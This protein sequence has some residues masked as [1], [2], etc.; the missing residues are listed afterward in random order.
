MFSF[1][2]NLFYSRKDPTFNYYFP[3]CRFW[4]MAMGGL[5]SVINLNLNSKLLTNFLGFFGLFSILFS[6]FY[7]NEADYYPGYIGLIPTIGTVA[8]IIAGKNSIINYYVLSTRVFT[9]IGKISFPMYLW[10]WPLLVF[11]RII[12][13][14]LQ[15]Y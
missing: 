15:D 6:A 12:Y 1:F 4:E 10:H 9:F 5:L 3:L 11:A 13:K 2:F 14:N 7:I 8:L